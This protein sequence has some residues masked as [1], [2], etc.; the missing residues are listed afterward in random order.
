MADEQAEELCVRPML[1]WSWI[2]DCCAIVSQPKFCSNLKHK[3]FG[4]L[5]K[6]SFR[7]NPLAIHRDVLWRI[8]SEG[9]Q[10]LIDFSVAVSALQFP[11]N[12]VR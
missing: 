4:Y 12:A 10:K 9:T 8:N 1:G 11:S 3:F 6:G 7:I 5:R 2:D